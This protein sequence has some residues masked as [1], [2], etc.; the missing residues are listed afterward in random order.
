MTSSDGMRPFEPAIGAA[1]NAVRARLDEIEVARE[2]HHDEWQALRV[3]T[4]WNGDSALALAKPRRVKPKYVHL[5]VDGAPQ[6]Y[7]SGLGILAVLVRG[8]ASQ[9]TVDCMVDDAEVRVTLPIS[10]L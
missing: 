3:R 10:D 7:K 6:E 9:I 5:T 4:Y 1:V 8:A 2:S